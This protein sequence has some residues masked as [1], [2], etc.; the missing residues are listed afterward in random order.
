MLPTPIKKFKKNGK[1]ALII[2]SD[3][4]LQDILR[5]RFQRLGFQVNVV[6]NEQEGVEYMREHS[7]D[8]VFFDLFPQHEERLEAFQPT[9][10]SPSKIPR[11]FLMA[12]WYDHT[13]PERLRH[14][15]YEHV[16]FINTYRD[17]DSLESIVTQNISI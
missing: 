14:F 4:D 7:P 1:S 10:S 12:D 8:V 16:T 11:F 2:E 5:F 9:A 6:K 17:I 3:H 13:I 15:G